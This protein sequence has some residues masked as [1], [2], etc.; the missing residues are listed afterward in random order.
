MIQSKISTVRTFLGNKVLWS[1]IK[2]LFIGTLTFVAELSFAYAIMMF[3]IK[4]GVSQQKLPDSLQFMAEYSPAITLGIVILAALFRGFTWWGQEFSCGSL[5]QT[6]RYVQRIRMVKSLMAG[7]STSTGKAISLFGEKT[8]AGGQAL[9]SLQNLGVHVFLASA[10]LLTLG[11]MSWPTTLITTG[12]LGLLLWPLSFLFKKVKV[13]G[14]GVTQEWDH[15]NRQLMLAFQN[16]FFLNISG[17]VNPTRKSAEKNLTS[18]YQHFLSYHRAYALSSA[19]PQVSGIIILVLASYY[20]AEHDLLASSLLVPY[21]Y[22]YLRFVQSG[23]AASARLSDLAFKWPQLQEIFSWWKKNR[24]LLEKLQDE[25]A[26]GEKSTVQL[27][28]PLGWQLQQ[29]S[30]CYPDEK[31]LL[32]DQYTVAI[33]AGQAT[34]FTGHSGSGKSTLLKLLLGFLEPTSGEVQVSCEGKLFATSKIKESIWNV[35]G[36]VGAESYLISGTIRENLLFG[37]KRSVTD[38]EMMETLKMADCAFVQNLKGGLNFQLGEGGEGL[39]TGQRQRLGLARALLGQPKTLILDE[40]T[41]NLD[42]E[43]QERLIDFLIS[44]KGKTT[45]VIVTHRRELLRLADRH[46]SLDKMTSI[47]KAS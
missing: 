9:M 8:T 32:F 47:A 13:A 46:F 26:L 27:Q 33:A 40:F 24:P 42:H 10:Y 18:F 35:T 3:M 4:L 37:M 36:Y 34:V 29:V 39:S 38:V 2:G 43:S 12:A 41:A 23:S 16:L 6:F 20:S 7:A 25:Q 44:L 45:L 31:S 22:I 15:V 28:A 30:F 14:T 11:M 17:M 1:L 5:E 21:F 19:M